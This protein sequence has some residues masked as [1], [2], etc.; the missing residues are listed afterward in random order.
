MRNRVHYA[1]GCDTMRKELEQLNEDPM[2]ELCPGD[3]LGEIAQSRIA[4]HLSKTKCE[5]CLLATAEASSP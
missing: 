2:S 5:E 3:V 4:A 1:A